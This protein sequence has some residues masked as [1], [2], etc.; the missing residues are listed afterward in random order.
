MLAVGH[1]IYGFG[2][3][4]HSVLMP[5]P[6]KAITAFRIWRLRPRLLPQELLKA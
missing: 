4:D 3:D 6:W 5:S 2:P 1:V